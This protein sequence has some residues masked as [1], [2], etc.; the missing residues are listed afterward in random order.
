MATENVP[1]KA[2]KSQFIY[3]RKLLWAFSIEVM[4][5]ILMEDVDIVLEVNGKNIPMNDFVKNILCGMITGSLGSLRGVDEDWKTI[6]I[7]MKR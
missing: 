7:S 2:K 5:G 4:R 1:V 3:A 6:R